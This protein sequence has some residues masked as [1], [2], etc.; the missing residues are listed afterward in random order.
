MLLLM[1][2]F[3]DKKRDMNWQRYETK[4]NNQ[5]SPWMDL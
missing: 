1:Q 2:K 4:R 3:T 5:I